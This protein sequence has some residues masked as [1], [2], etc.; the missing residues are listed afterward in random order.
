M[1]LTLVV[2]CSRA[3]QGVLWTG[4]RVSRI[5]RTTSWSILAGDWTYQMREFS[6][7]LRSKFLVSRFAA[8][9]AYRLKPELPNVLHN[10][11]FE[12]Q[13]GE[14]VCFI[15]WE[16]RLLTNKWNQVGVLGRT[17]SGKSTLAL[18]FFRFVE[19]TEGKIVID[20][21]DL[22]KIGLTDLR[23]RLSTSPISFLWWDTDS[24]PSIAIIPRQ[25]CQSQHFSPE[26]TSHRGPDDIE[27]NLTLHSWCLRR[28]P[29]Y[30]DRTALYYLPFPHF[31]LTSVVVQG[32]SSGPSHPNRR[33]RSRNWGR[34]L[35]RFPWP[36]FLRIRGRR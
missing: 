5:H 3:C 13:P 16:I 31:V 29:G 10:I 12:V 26:L 23:S 22:A 1:T 8:L 11:S 9:F 24:I 33:E 6:H 34:Q 28:I 7:S 32:P 20:G 27:R 17:G 4:T 19:A 30:R 15:L 21:T 25:C 36:G 35:E 18:S 2:G 14:K